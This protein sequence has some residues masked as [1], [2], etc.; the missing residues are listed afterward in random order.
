MIVA[1]GILDAIPPGTGLMAVAALLVVLAFYLFV[2]KMGAPIVRIVL[3]ILSLI[4]LSGYLSAG[5]PEPLRRVTLSMLSPKS[6][7]VVP[8][9]HPVPVMLALGGAQ[10]VPMSTQTFLSPPPAN[11][12]HIHILVDGKLTSM[13]MSELAEVTLGPGRHTIA[14]EFVDPYHRSYFP[15]IIDRVHVTARQGLVGGG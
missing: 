5:S 6:G 14:A 3:L 1:D 15:R 13:Q 2:R 12:G 9:R 8:A 4:V 10:V 7:A 11:A